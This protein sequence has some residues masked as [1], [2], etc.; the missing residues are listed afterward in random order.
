MNM[1]KK[2]IP[3]NTN[4]NRPNYFDSLTVN[5][6]EDAILYNKRHDAVYEFKLVLKQRFSA[7]EEVFEMALENAEK[8]VAFY[9]YDDVL[10]EIQQ[11]IT[12]VY[13]GDREKTLTILCEL[14]SNLIDSIR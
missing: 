12:S 11:A 5:K 6:I 3:V 4:T 1:L 7:S 10:K 2:F 14:K 13:E 9:L 8:Q